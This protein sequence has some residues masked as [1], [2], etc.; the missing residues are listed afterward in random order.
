MQAF[1]AAKSGACYVAPYVNRIDNM[2]YDGV[3]VTEQ[4][5]NILKNNNLDCDVLGASF[6]NSNQVLRLVECGVGSITA[7]PSVIDNLSK[8]QAVDKAIEDFA[9]DFRKPTGKD[10]FCS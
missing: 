7:A 1:L 10:T 8:N 4:I 2:G 3:A 9:N 6:K 5:H